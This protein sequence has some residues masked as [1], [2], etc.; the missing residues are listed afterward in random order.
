MTTMCNLSNS[1][2]PMEEP[3]NGD[4]HAW[5]FNRLPLSQKQKSELLAGLM[6]EKNMLLKEKEELLDELTMR[7]EYMRK[8]DVSKCECESDTKVAEPAICL[9]CFNE[10]NTIPS[11]LQKELNFVSTSDSPAVIDQPNP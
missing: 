8:L 11:E 6:E 9:K 7:K 1:G 2:N 5:V 10:Q 3:C 4:V